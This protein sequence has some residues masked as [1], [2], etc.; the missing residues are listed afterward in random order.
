MT[1]SPGPAPVVSRVD[2]FTRPHLALAILVLGVVSAAPA[3]GVALVKSAFSGG[4][5]AASDASYSLVAT[6]GEAGIVGEVADGTYV[7]AEGFWG[8]VRSVAT[9]VPGAL[10]PIVFTNGLLQNA[11]NPFRFDTDISFSVSSAAATRLEVYDVGG[12][13]VRTLVSGVRQPGRHRVQWDG[14]D[15][16][17]NL[18]G[19]GVYFYRLSV[20]DWSDTRKMLR[21]N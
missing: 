9:G 8:G 16:S 15:G 1:D 7:L 10:G 18:V 11:P 2:R 13:R 5:M 3:G 14:R 19:S 21:L 17:R 12:R 20:G 4:A 6:V